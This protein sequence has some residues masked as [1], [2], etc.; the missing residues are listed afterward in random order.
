MDAL[1]KPPIQVRRRRH[2]ERP[3]PAR[4][5]PGLLPPDLH[6]RPRGPVV[7]ARKISTPCAST[8]S[9]AAARSSPTRPAAARPSTPL[10]AGSSPSCFPTTRWCPFP[11]TTSSTPTRSV[12][13]CRDVQYTK[14]AGGGRGFPAARRRQDQRPLGDHL[15]Q[16]RHR[17]RTRAAH[18]HRVQGLHLRKRHQ[19]RRQ[20]RDLFH[21]AVTG[22]PLNTWF[23][24][25]E[26]HSEPRRLNR[27]LKRAIMLIV[28]CDCRATVALGSHASARGCL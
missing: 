8:S 22:S 4:S 28:S 21:V 26:A 16:V 5:Q 13:T 9:P 20:H 6:P 24:R 18:R 7:F 27:R 23:G 12:P 11:R 10:S 2:S 19:D 25:P 14:G 17:L 1:R 3:V 15:L